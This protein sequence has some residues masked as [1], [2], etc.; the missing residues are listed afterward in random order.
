MKLIGVTCMFLAV[1]AG[2][3]F[4][5][6]AVIIGGG[7]TEKEASA[8]LAEMV[9]RKGRAA[10]AF[11][12]SLTF[13]EKFPRVVQ[14]ADYPGLRPGLHVVVFGIC[15]TGAAK[16]WAKAL[17][18][19]DVSGVYAR[20]LR[21]D[22]RDMCPRLDEGKLKHR[23]VL[24][25]RTSEAGNELLLLRVVH[26]GLGADSDQVVVLLVHAG[27]LLDVWV[28]PL[29]PDG[30]FCPARI[31]RLSGRVHTECAEHVAADNCF[32]IYRGA[33][34]LTAASGAIKAKALKRKLLR[35]D[36]AE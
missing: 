32:E 24:R 22:A 28:P 15:E 31:D 16:A 21:G 4:A 20:P 9:H 29:G 18:A 35:R 26:V 30:A 12:N 36:C 19:A 10:G 14:S 11:L 1:L 17:K 3:A 27:A 13:P 2:A 5:E 23:L 8:W 25:R 34:E 7:G 33:F 6:P